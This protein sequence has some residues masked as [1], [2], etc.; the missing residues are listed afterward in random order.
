MISKYENFTIYTL[1]FVDDIVK[2][3]SLDSLPVGISFDIIPRI[4]SIKFSR[5]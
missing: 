2:P 4:L 5:N 1:D 3:I